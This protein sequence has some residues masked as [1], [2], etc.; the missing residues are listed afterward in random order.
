[1]VRVSV[2]VMVCDEVCLWPQFDHVSTV[3]FTKAKIT[4]KKIKLVPLT[5]LITHNDPNQQKK[6][7]E[8]C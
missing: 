5:N 1:M 4:V 6:N 3:I 2:R 8:P 7:K